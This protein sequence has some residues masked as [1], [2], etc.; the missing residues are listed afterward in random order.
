MSGY[1]RHHGGGGYGGGYGGGH[2]GHHGGG[3][4][5]GHRDGG[6]RG[7]HGH[8][9]DDAGAEYLASIFGT[10]KDKVNCSFYFK[11]GACHYGD[12][13]SRLHN[14][15]TYSQT[16]LIHN[17]YRSPILVNNA[18]APITESMLQKHYDDFYE[19]VFYEIESKYGEIE[20]MNV[21]ENLGDHIV[22]NVYIKF[23]KEEDAEKAQDALNER[24][25]GGEAVAAELSPV[26]NFRE[27][28]CRDYEMGECTRGGFCNFM[29]LKPISKHLRK[30]LYNRRSKEKQG[31]NPDR[32]RGGRSRSRSPRRRR[33]RRSPPR[34]RK[35]QVDLDWSLNY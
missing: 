8:H 3:H 31:Y 2:G 30:K 1:G 18:Q 27:A 23:Y 28:C 17:M 35:K 15:P 24:W 22:G 19:E 29:H 26:T 6:R 13:C 34:R 20:E 7:G 9:E 14:R 12:K 25:F 10:E 5:G 4:H 16:I 11:I 33:D 21:C 32:R